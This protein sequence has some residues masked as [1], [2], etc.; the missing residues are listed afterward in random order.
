MSNTPEWFQ[1][2]ADYQKPVPAAR[3]PFPK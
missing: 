2:T 3:K 1:L